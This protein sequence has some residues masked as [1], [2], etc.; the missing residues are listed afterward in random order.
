MARKSL[1]RSRKSIVEPRVP[2]VNVP[3]PLFYE[4]R[5]LLRIA[6]SSSEEAQTVL[7]L[8]VQIFPTAT[9]KSKTVKPRSNRMSGLRKRLKML[10]QGNSG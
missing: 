5:D 3:L 2:A 9:S 10:D 4:I 1:P 8:F 7:M 6:A